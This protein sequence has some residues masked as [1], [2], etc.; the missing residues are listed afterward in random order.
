LLS[1][2]HQAVFNALTTAKTAGYKGTE[3]L[4][5][6]LCRLRTDNPVKEAKD[7]LRIVIKVMPPWAI[8]TIW[9]G[10]TDHLILFEREFLDSSLVIPCIRFWT[11]GYRRDE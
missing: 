6:K 9:G 8:D 11:T 10:L 3:F 2:S 4:L 5:F 7:G 1:H